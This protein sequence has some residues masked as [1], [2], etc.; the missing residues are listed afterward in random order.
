MDMSFKKYFFKGLL[1]L[2]G[3]NITNAMVYAQN[4]TVNVKKDSMPLVTI[5][6]ISLPQTE[7]AALFIT[8]KLL[9]TAAVSSVAGEVLYKTP[10]ANITNTFN[11]QLNGLTV[12]QGSGEPGYDGGSLFIRGVGSYNYGAYSIYINGFQT[13]FS[14]LQYLSPS[15]IDNISIF[16]DAASLAT[17]G[18]KGANGVIWVTTK[19]G[20]AGKIKIQ[21]QARTSY[22]RPVNINK[23]LG[24]YEYATLYNEAISNDNNRIWSPAYT[25]VQLEQY[26]NG[27]G[28]NTNWYDEV[29]KRT[30]PFTTADVT[31]SGGNEDARFFVMM[32]Y[33]KDQG[34]YKVK[35]DDTHSN[36]GQQQFNLR[37]SLDFKMFSIFE[38]K[39]DLGGRT[40]D[41]K[42]PNFQ[43]A[44]LWNNLASYP[45]NIYPAKNPDGSFPGTTTY[46]NNPLA[47]INELGTS[48]SHDRTIQANFTLKEK[49]DF[50][51][52]GLY[53]SE[54]ASYSSWA[55]GTYNVTKN[56]ARLIDSIPQTTDQNT[57]YT[58]YDD[59]GTNQWNWTQFQGQLG[60]DKAIGRHAII[61]AVNYLQ[62]TYNVDANLN[63]TAGV[64]MKYANQNLSG[65]LHYEFDK[66]YA[67]ELGFA[68][69]GSDDYA[70]GNRFGFYPSLSAAWNMSNEAFLSENK[71]IDLLKLRVSAGKSGYDRFAGGRYLY[72]Q[73][74]AYSGGYQT[75]NGTPNWNGGISQSNVPNTGIFAEQSMKYNIGIEAKLIKMFDITIDAF[76]DKRSKIVSRDNALLAV[77]GTEAPYENIGKVT[78]KGMEGS[79]NFTNHIH[80]LNYQL[81]VSASYNSNKIN[82]MAELPPVTPGAAKTGRSIATPFGYEANGFYATSDFDASGNLKAGIPIPGFGPVQPGDIKYRDLNGDNKI[83]ERDIVPI[84]NSFIPKL[85]YTFIA[86][87]DIAGFDFRLL[88]QGVSG[89]SINLLDAGN[90]TIAFQ[91]NSN[92]Y[93]LA[94]DRWAYYPDKGIDTRATATYPRLSTLDNRNN[95]RSST[96][97]MKDGSFLRIRNIEIG[98]S[99]PQS[100]LKKVK[101]SNARI[102][103]SGINLFTWSPLLKDYHM[104]PETMTGYA[105]LKSMSVG[106]TVNF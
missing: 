18:M 79:I 6:K 95:Y 102:F 25:P 77:F 55:R 43:G 64:S 92:A 78:N 69:S 60:Y 81:G 88:L 74:Y 37:T 33:M 68:Y 48:S 47:T 83:D 84:G 14:Y 86:S 59:R 53:L 62:S 96:F 91:N 32:N 87:A 94:K 61:A 16:K 7:A 70:K 75:G 54:A 4:Q 80:K 27:T 67:A 45:A 65:R 34:L 106:F 19:R 66:R 73:Y 9:S 90:Q 99:L 23:P 85:S 30:T 29:L 13:T 1:L 5:N 101:F 22:R 49:L 72:Q 98:Y 97:W 2:L 41:R 52:K 82:Y 105:E 8:N 31:L 71:K 89:R 42:Y 104:D 11:G 46:P 100:L 26:K 39:V 103:V 15:E 63:G 24:S 51:T 17:F 44:A 58:V 56:Y 20:E 10:A 93:A 21:L 36:A 38:G 28:I 3:L 50:I 40:E 35:N 76:L 57:N 12:L